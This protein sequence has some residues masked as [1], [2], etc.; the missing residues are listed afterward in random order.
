MLSHTTVLRRIIQDRIESKVDNFSATFDKFKDGFKSDIDVTIK[1]I[2]YT[3]DNR[4]SGT[5]TRVGNLE[6]K[7]PVFLHP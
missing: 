7:P 5:N 1:N 4:A 6:T 3:I 2:L